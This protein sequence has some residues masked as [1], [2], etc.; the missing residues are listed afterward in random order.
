MTFSSLWFL[1][2]GSEAYTECCSSTESL[3]QEGKVGKEWADPG[4]WQIVDGRDIGKEGGG[5]A[6]KD[7]G[8]R[9]KVRWFAPG[10]VGRFERI[11][12]SYSVV[13]VSCTSCFHSSFI[14]GKG[15]FDY[16]REL[17]GRR[18][19]RLLLVWENA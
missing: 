4:K 14:R 11:F 9:G 5:G 16:R 17:R 13:C 7:G 1:N 15:G 6:G 2:W 12:F 18:D 19:L 10:F 3:V 8:R